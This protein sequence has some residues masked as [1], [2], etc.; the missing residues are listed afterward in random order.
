MLQKKI[1]GNG[2]LSSEELC[3]QGRALTVRPEARTESAPAAR[4][5]SIACPIAKP[6]K[7]EIAPVCLPAERALLFG[8]KGCHW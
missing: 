2:F 4:M 3:A 8:D 5:G 7:S 1:R 6:A